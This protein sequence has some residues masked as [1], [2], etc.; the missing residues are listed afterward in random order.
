MKKNNMITVTMPLSEFNAMEQREKFWQDNYN[1]LL[2]IVKR[3][4]EQ[5]ENGFYTVRDDE[6]EELAND[7]ED[8]LND[9]DE[10]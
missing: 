3:Y 1:S 6:R 8:Y 2:V 5:D 4:A 9:L 7:L 10:W